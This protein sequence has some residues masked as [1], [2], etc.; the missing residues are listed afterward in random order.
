MKKRNP[1][2]VF[3]LS[4]ITF[5]IY[6]IYWL[7][8]TKTVLNEKT[9]HHT[10]TIFMLVV[11]ILILIA[12][13]VLL[14]INVGKQVNNAT[15]GFNG[16]SQTISTTK[17]SAGAIILI[18]VGFITT[19]IFSIIWFFKFSKAI[20]EYTNGKMSTAISFLILYLI[21]L[22]GVALIQDT[23]ND[24]EENG[25]PPSQPMAGFTPQAQA[26]APPAAPVPPSPYHPSHT[27]IHVKD[28]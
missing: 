12:G 23:F 26:P 18:F 3:A 11:P 15:Y 8:K 28:S 13:Y 24:M 2:A 7:V 4:V 21:H 19:F 6:D 20:N 14:I 25:I 9:K 1:L 16:G 17:P 5:G 10:P 22:I 27:D